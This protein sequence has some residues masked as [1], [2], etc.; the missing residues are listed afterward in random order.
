[1]VVGDDVV[2]HVAILSRTLALVLLV[3]AATER[4]LAGADGAAT[5]ICGIGPVEAALATA[6]AIDEVGPDALLHVG[7]AGAATLD[8]PAVVLGSE[9]VYCDIVDPLARIPRVERVE[10]DRALLATARAALPDA[11]ALP[12]G[13]SARVGGG[14]RVDVEAME[15]FAVLRAAQVA[16][17]PALE[18]RAISNR[19]DEVD[20]SL[21]RF[22]EALEVLA[23]ALRRVLE[24]L[25]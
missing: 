8:P 1:L 3:V 10:P 25:R 23:D 5:A 16:G 24:A 21:W 4:E 18:L 2:A 22:D 13:T 6:R 19:V 7:I 11:V 20:R 12:I 15:G 9:A 14:R 17:V